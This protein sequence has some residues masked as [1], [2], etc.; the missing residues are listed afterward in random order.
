[1]LEI[2]GTRSVRK[3]DVGFDSSR[4]P[5]RCVRNLPAIVAIQSLTEIARATRVEVA[6]VAFALQNIDIS[7]TAHLPLLACR[8][9][10]RNNLIRGKTVR[11]RR[12]ATARQPS[13]F[14]TL[15]AKAGGEGS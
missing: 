11:L 15:R 9:V 12:E 6:W 1:M 7:E 10:A 13:L 8:A 5:L 2:S 14:T 4:L 3:C